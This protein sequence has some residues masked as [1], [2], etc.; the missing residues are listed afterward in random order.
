MWWYLAL[1][2]PVPQRHPTDR[3]VCPS[4]F[5][6]DRNGRWDADFACRGSIFVPPTRRRRVL[7]FRR[8]CR[9]VAP[10][11][12]DAVS[13]GAA[14]GD[15]FQHAEH[16]L[17]RH[18]PLGPYDVGFNYHLR[19]ARSPLYV[20]TGGDDERHDD[21]LNDPGRRPLSC[22]R[23][24]QRRITVVSIALLTAY[25]EFRTGDARSADLGLPVH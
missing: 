4:L 24:G 11:T 19:T 18:L 17:S 20:D 2:L 21:H 5:D 7:E 25:Q 10:S 22:R 3:D 14:S 12:A 1:A 15:R 16:Q 6:G 23:A 8:R 13:V 9:H